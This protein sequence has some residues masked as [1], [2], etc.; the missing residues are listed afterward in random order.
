ME[1]KQPSQRDI[2]QE[3]LNEGIGVDVHES[4][5]SLQYQVYDKNLPPDMREYGHIPIEKNTGYYQNVKALEPYS[6]GVP[7]SLQGKKIA[8][9]L[10]QDAEQRTGGK[11]VPDSSQTRGGYEL[12]DRYGYGKEF[13]LSDEELDSMLT[14]TEKSMRGERKAQLGKGIESLASDFENLPASSVDRGRVN[15][16]VYDILS[17][18]RNK[19]VPNRNT[20]DLLQNIADVAQEKGPEA[21]EWLRKNKDFLA[22]KV[23]SLAPMIPAAGGGLGL[24]SM[25]A[26][27]DASA[28]LPF[29]GSEGVGEGSEL[30]PTDA[31]SAYNKAMPQSKLDRNAHYKKLRKALEGK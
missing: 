19:G 5:D 26:S 25:L 10:Y 31:R 13:G 14:P 18:L 3:L 24:A 9:R 7:K 2:L 1:R 12:H 27:E 8:T 17:D 28:A 15:S 23:K 6:S 30:D 11:I 22:G 20:T 4:D 21:A 16:Y 29:L